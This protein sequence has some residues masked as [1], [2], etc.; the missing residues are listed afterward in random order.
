MEKLIKVWVELITTF[1]KDID[2]IPV[3]VQKEL[4]IIL[5]DHI[6]TVLE[7]ALVK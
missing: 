6:D 3:S 4:N 5:A 7:N 1:Q 2:D